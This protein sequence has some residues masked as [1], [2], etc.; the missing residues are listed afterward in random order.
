M[1]EGAWW[2]AF[3]QAGGLPDLETWLGGPDAR[4]R[5]R[6]RQRIAECRYTWVAD[7]GAGLGLDRIGMS[8]LSHQCR[9]TGVEPSAEMRAASEKMSTA[10]SLSKSG[11][12]TEMI[13]GSIEK[14]PLENAS[15]DLV[16]CRHVF[17]HLPTVDAAMAEMIRV[18]KL[19]VIVVFFMRP[20]EET[21][22]TREQDGLWQNRWSK[23]HIEEIAMRSHRSMA[24]FWETLGSEVLFHIYVEDAREL[25]FGLIQARLPK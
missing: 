20:G 25:D 9:Y 11:Q 4:S 15:V 21:Y 24:M 7:I 1:S 14:I 10:Y 2:D 8:N 18:A 6:I 5:V 13:G 23:S 19:E 16:Y 12:Q 22:L 17:E 3:A